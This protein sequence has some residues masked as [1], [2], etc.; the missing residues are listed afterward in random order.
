[1]TG[2]NESNGTGRAHT[3]IGAGSILWKHSMQNTFLSGL[4][5]NERM[6]SRTS[7]KAVYQ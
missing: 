4:L 3:R 5:K 7:D 1:M 6:S 2:G